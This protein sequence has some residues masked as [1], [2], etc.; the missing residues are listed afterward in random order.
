MYLIPEERCD[1]QFVFPLVRGG[2]IS[3]SVY[4]SGDAKYVGISATEL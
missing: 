3:M 1:S 4:I 2:I